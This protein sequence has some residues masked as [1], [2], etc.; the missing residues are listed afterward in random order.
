MFLFL[1]ITLRQGRKLRLRVRFSII[2]RSI[3]SVSFCPEAPDD[4][5]ASRLALRLRVHWTALKMR[6]IKPRH[7]AMLRAAELATSRRPVALMDRALGLN[8]S[9][10]ALLFRFVELALQTIYSRVINE[11]ISCMGCRRLMR[12]GRLKPL[13]GI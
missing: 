2:L 10:I 13:H 9:Q 5:A 6:R 3:S 12:F 8:L 4:R 7:R 11:I 1:P